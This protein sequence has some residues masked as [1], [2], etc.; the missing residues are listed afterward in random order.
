M[1]VIT[2]N[3]LFQASQIF[4]IGLLKEHY[5]DIQIKRKKALTGSEKGIIISLGGEYSPEHLRFDN[6]QN[7]SLPCPNIMILDWLEKGDRMMEDDIKY[8]RKDF[9]LISDVERFGC[10]NAPV[11]HIGTVVRNLNYS[12]RFPS[13]DKSFGNALSL[14]RAYIKSKLSTLDK[15]KESGVIWSRGEHI[16]DKIILCSELPLKWRNYKEKYFLICPD[17]QSKTWVLHSANSQLFPIVSNG[18]HVYLHPAFYIAKFNTREDA[19]DSAFLSMDA[20]K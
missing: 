8:L 17:P 7:S 16:S 5:P 14:A 18:K 3:A 6:H 19:V 11:L 12:G 15:M 4:A 1:E 20:I 2:H 13:D 9:K 10:K